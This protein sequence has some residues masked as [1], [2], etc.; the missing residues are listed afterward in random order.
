MPSI[1]K[2]RLTNVIYENGAKRYN[3]M[4]FHFD[5]HNGAFLLENGGG[6]TV[7]IQT[8]L[9]AVIPHIDMADRKIKDTL[10]LDGNPAHIAIEWILN[11]Q[12]RR[13]GVTAT[14]LYI[15]NHELKSIKYV[16]EYDGEDTESIED[17]PF[18][19]KTK[20][21]ENRSASRGEINDYYERMKNKSHDART[22]QTIIEYGKYIEE[23]FKI[24]PNEWRKIA[25][26]NSGEGN[27]DEF[28][29]RCKT[30]QQLLDELLI[31]TVEE[32]IQGEKNQN[33]ASVFEKQR[34]HFKANQ[35]LQEEIKAFEQVKVHIDG[36]IEAYK[37]L[38]HARK[39]Y[40]A[41]Q[42]NMYCMY[43]G[44][45]KN[46]TSN[47]RKEEVLYQE[48]EA[49]EKEENTLKHKELSL[50][51]MEKENRIQGIEEQLNQD[52]EGC[53]QTVKK[54]DGVAARKQNIE[55]TMLEKKKRQIKERQ[56]QLEQELADVDVHLGTEEIQKK[57]DQNSQKIQGYYQATVNELEETVSA[58][59]Q[60]LERKKQDKEQQKNRKEQKNKQL[61]IIASRIGKIEGALE[62]KKQQMES[63]LNTLLKD[64]QE[65]SVVSEYMQWKERLRRSHI[66]QRNEEKELE[67]CVESKK[68][69]EKYREE[70]RKKIGQLK[71]QQ[72]E[73]Q[74]TL[75]TWKKE[76]KALIEEIELKSHA[77]Y[78][79]DSIYA[80]EESIL[81]RLAEKKHHLEVTLDEALQEEWRIRGVKRLSQCFP[82]WIQ[83]L[84]VAN[85]NAYKDVAT[86][87]YIEQQAT[88]LCVITQDELYCHI[89]HNVLTDND[90]IG[91]IL[92]PTD[93][94]GRTKSEERQSG[95][96]KLEVDVPI[97][98]DYEEKQEQLRKK[99]MNEWQNISELERQ[100]RQFF[101]HYSYEE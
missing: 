66:Q 13:Y 42:Y 82:T 48:K 20:E 11:E 41:E 76:E 63:L 22:F 64:I 96:E 72:A 44:L 70:L 56:N 100:A 12:P 37:S 55:I 61:Q 5:G 62:V 69:A 50:E 83:T 33:F 71:Q 58:Y 34:E 53:Q 26:I 39:N 7:F 2:I 95:V 73:V 93:W 28:F 87:A 25:T 6:K 52:Y 30:T 68:N 84:V 51:V 54:Y 21:G 46:Y 101:Q 92:Y 36:Y 38:D 40:T 59:K 99:L 18:V 29:N 65:E 90:S 80:K 77:L 15:E 4:I 45:E 27:V 10:S 19:V 24:I 97:D 67:E 35:R 49:L 14:S 81:Q 17:I 31:P 43:K 23:R 3:D 94:Q 32:A 85:K 57:L 88:P 78:I 9:Q 79:S 47:R 60:E 91:E 75:A 86:K 89:M 74:S 98:E 1:S 8:V 16:Y